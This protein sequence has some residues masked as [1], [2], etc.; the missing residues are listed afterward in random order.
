MWAAQGGVK[1]LI[2]QAVKG[3]PIGTLPLD[4]IVKV[5]ENGVLS[6]Y[7][8]VSQGKPSSIYD[9]SCNGTWLLR[10]NLLNDLLP[11]N[12]VKSDVYESSSIHGWL[13]NTMFQRYDPGLRSFIFTAKI[14]YVK[15]GSNGTLQTG[16]SGLPCRVFLPSLSEIGVISRAGVTFKDGA[17][18][19][20]FISDADG[21]NPEAMKKRIALYKGNPFEW[22]PRSVFFGCPELGYPAVS[23]SGWISQSS[24]N[25]FSAGVRP[26]FV[27]SKVVQVADDGTI[28]V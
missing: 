20:Y 12:S 18:L 2:Y 11:W 24:N 26:I 3:V 16:S 10:K 21:T 14:P 17:K 5:R 15:G 6:E 1:K 22:W 28:L 25:S 13:Q 27:L 9:N 7:I 19:S 23:G 8:I 4:S